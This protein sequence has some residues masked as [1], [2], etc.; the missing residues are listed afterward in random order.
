[1][2]PSGTSGFAPND[3]EVGRGGELWVSIGGRGT[4]GAVYRIR[5]KEAGEYDGSAE[6]S[7]HFDLASRAPGGVPPPLRRNAPDA[8]PEDIALARD[9]LAAAD[10]RAA[11]DACARPAAELLRAKPSLLRLR[12]LMRA[13]GD[14]NL[15]KPSAEAFTGY[16]LA[17]ARIFEAG[18]WQFLA[19]CR[20][21]AR[22]ALGAGGADLDREAARLLAMLRDDDPATPGRLLALIE[23]GSTPQD[24]VHYLLCLAKLSAPAAEGEAG[25]AAAALLGLAGKLGGAQFRAKQSW[26]ER[27]GEGIAMLCQRVPGLPAALLAHPGFAKPDNAVFALALPAEA[28]RDAARAFAAAVA[29]GGPGSASVV[30]LL[31]SLPPPDAAPALRQPRRRPRAAGCRRCR[32]SPARPPLP[33]ARRSPSRTASAQNAWRRRRFRPSHAAR[34]ASAR[35]IARHPRGGAPFQC[36]RIRRSP[37]SAAPLPMTCPI[38]APPRRGSACPQK[39]TRRTGRRLWR[40]PIGWRVM[41]PRAKRFSKAAPARRATPA[42]APSDRR[43]R[44][45]PVDFPPRI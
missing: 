28:R 7:P 14:W 24:D 25:R 44:A 37:R 12:C 16:E 33:T 9:L 20:A 36:W 15:D 11:F 1:M 45:S 18:K 5:A 23:A 30:A 4:R 43:S 40:P 13:L 27:V 22:G 19:D 42:T 41:P 35:G 21:A 32:C 26:G 29:E 34:A 8:P 39:A 31:G 10:A 17:S 38:S 2:E 3:I 6:W